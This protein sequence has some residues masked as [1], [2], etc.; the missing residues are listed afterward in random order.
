MQLE[1]FVVAESVSIDQTTNEVSLLGVLE[2]V[3]AE[4]FPIIVPKCAAISLWRVE[5]GDENQDWQALIR[6]ASPGQGSQ[7]FP[8]NFRPQANA[9][10]HR[11]VQ[12]IYGVPL[13]EEG[14]LRFEL[15]LNGHHIADH[16][17]TVRREEGAG[18]QIGTPAVAP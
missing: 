6:L 1:F 18:L 11:I 7:D 16:F 13:G 17:V 8:T 5:P 2:D 9:R 4:A 14:D 12:R 15:L 3:V 10:R